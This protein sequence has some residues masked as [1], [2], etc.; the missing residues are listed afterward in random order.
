MLLRK[1]LFL[2]AFIVSTFSNSFAATD[3]GEGDDSKMAGVSA[4]M[5]AAMDNDIEGVRFFS[6]SDKALID[7][8]NLGGATA[9]HLAARQGN[10]EIV[11]VLVK[12]GANLDIT[13]NEG[14][15]P[16]MRAALAGNAPIVKLLVNNGA[17]AT[18][19]NSIGE[20]VIINS[21]SSQCF[22]CL[23]LVLEGSN[24]ADRM[25]DETLKQQLSEA[26]AISRNRE[27]SKSRDLLESYLNSLLKGEEIIPT[28]VTTRVAS[29]DKGKK[30]K[31]IE[32]SAVAAVLTGSKKSPFAKRYIYSPTK[33]ENNIFD[34]EVFSLKEPKDKLK[35]TTITPKAKLKG[36]GYKFKRSKDENVAIKSTA[37][38]VAPISASR[39]TIVKDIP[40][41][42]KPVE[43]AVT[44]TVKPVVENDVVAKPQTELKSSIIPQVKPVANVEA[45]KVVEQKID[46]KKVKP[47]FVIGSPSN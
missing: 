38:S 42:A 19:R 41:P 45:K 4:L 28:L 46:D 26:F 3:L 43:K 2:T 9:L 16:L 24:F 37:L 11:D 36:A 21:A 7:K 8:R 30:F 22:E 6:K 5:S 32:D 34:K 40:A 35:S 29:D 12:G 17:D 23:N 15:T 47:R 33:D 27:D 44:P 10:F 13:D 31:L 25:E 14:W 18:K 1:I 20:S 39:E